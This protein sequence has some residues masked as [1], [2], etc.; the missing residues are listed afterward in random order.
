MELDLL[1]FFFSAKQ[2]RQRLDHRDKSQPV[3]V[4]GREKQQQLSS[5]TVSSTVLAR[6]PSLVSIVALLIRQRQLL[7][8]LGGRA[9]SARG[10][11]RTPRRL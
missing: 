3:R 5:P 11:E 6:V 8:P 9:T 7:G 1:G 4:K 2:L 10:R